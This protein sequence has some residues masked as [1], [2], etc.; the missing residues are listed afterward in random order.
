MGRSISKTKKKKQ[1]K[2]V[3]DAFGVR[4][5]GGG[6]PEGGEGRLPTDPESGLGK[7]LDDKA[8]VKSFLDVID[9][10]I[11][12]IKQF[13]SPDTRKLFDLIFE[14]EIGSFSSDI[15]ENMGQASALKEKYP[16]LYEKNAKRWSG[17]VGDLR[18]KLLTEIWNYI[19]TEMSNKDFARLRDQFF[20]DV[21]P[22]VV[23][24]LE[25]EKSKGKD[26]YQ[27]G[28][29]ERKL[30]RLKAKKESGSLTSQEQ[31]DF[32]R[33]AKRLSE[34]GVDIDAIPA[35]KAASTREAASAALASNMIA[36][37]TTLHWDK[38]QWMA[39]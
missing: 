14:D 8:A 24:K 22:S 39:S 29:D 33:L 35:G 12:D 34:Q 9:E 16:E 19:E 10:H 31:K 36:S 5:E 6:D 26:D 28:L 15:K 7:A 37:R 38:R 3:D 20:S 17:F 4:G 18:K 21:D 2:S 27:K 25:R 11:E 23:R 1:E 30:S 32:D 13:L